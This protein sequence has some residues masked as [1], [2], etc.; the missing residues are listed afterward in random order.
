MMNK[1][2]HWQTPVVDTKSVSEVLGAG[3]TAGP[4]APGLVGGP[5]PMFGPS[6]SIAGSSGDNFEALDWDPVAISGPPTRSSISGPAGG[7]E[8]SSGPQPPS[9]APGFGPPVRSFFS[10]PPGS[11]QVLSGPRD[12]RPAPAL[13]PTGRLYPVEVVGSEPGSFGPPVFVPGDGPPV[14]PSD[15][16]LKEDITPVGKSAVGIPLYTFRY[17]GQ[18]GRFEGVMAQDVLQVFP[19]AVVTGPQGYLFVDYARLGL[20]LRRLQ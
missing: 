16:R 7:I 9:P 14:Q 5:I 2:K 13:G 11:A 17:R 18:E 8:F 19:E 6:E 1:R 20:K 15:I 3:E 12:P 10:G 4:M